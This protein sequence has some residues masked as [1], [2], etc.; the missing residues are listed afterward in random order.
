MLGADPVDEFALLT[1][2][3]ERISVEPAVGPLRRVFSACRTEVAR[4]H[5]SLSCT[6]TSAPGR[7]RTGVQNLSSRAGRPPAGPQLAITCYAAKH[8][9]ARFL[10]VEVEICFTGRT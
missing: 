3:L 8:G 6:A 4:C 1:A 9:V 7:T 5:V 10:V 2:G